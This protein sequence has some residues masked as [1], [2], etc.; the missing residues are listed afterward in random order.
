MKSAI[1]GLLSFGSVV[2][3]SPERGDAGKTLDLA[4]VSAVVISGEASSVRLTTSTSAPYRATI[5]SRREGWFARWYSSWFANDCSLAS[6]MKLEASTLR[7]DVAP[8]SW[9]DP[10]DCRVEISANIQPESSVSIDQAA[11]QAS[12]V[13][14]FS[15]IAINSKAADVSLDGHASTVELKGDALRANLAFGSVRQDENIA[16]TG[17]ALD[18]TLSFGQGVAVSYSVAATASFVDSTITNTAGAKPSVVIKG[19]FVRAIIR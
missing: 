19:D 16:I 10:S 13:G 6:D 18:A 3:A 2:L 4:G 12:M 1:L 15:T 14:S 8:S 9:L 7:I 5:G 11:L 17:K